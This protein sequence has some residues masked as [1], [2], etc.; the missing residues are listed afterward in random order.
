MCLTLVVCARGGRGDWRPCAGRGWEDGHSPL[1]KVFAPRALGCS[2]HGA[3]HPWS[4]RL[5]LRTR[6]A[7][8]GQPAQSAGSAWRWWGQAKQACGLPAQ[9]TTFRAGGAAVTSRCCYRKAAVASPP[10]GCWRFG[11]MLHVWKASAI[12][13]AHR[14]PQCGP[15]VEFPRKG[16]IVET[17]TNNVPAQED[18]EK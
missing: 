16:R 3:R 6:R 13:L 9:P 10:T 7:S 8:R 17:G 4:N 1:E 18:P 2:G 5:S 15:E 12:P 11:C 14:Q